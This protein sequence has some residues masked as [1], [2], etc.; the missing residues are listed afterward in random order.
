[1]EMS[2]VL[3]GLVAWVVFSVPASLLLGA[4]M[5]MGN[6]GPATVRARAS[7]RV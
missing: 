1:M 7:N 2:Q 6:K 4:F 3:T 5:G